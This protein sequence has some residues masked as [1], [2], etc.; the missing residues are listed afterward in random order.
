MHTLPLYKTEQIDKLAWP[1]VQRQINLHSPALSIVTDFTEQ[2]PQVIDSDTAAVALESLMKHSHVKMKI[3]L[4]KHQ[5]FAGIVTLADLT[6]QRILQKVASGI[7]RH[8]LTAQDF[9]QPKTALQSFDY[10]QLVNARVGDVVE[11]LKDNG[12]HHCLVTDRGAHEIRG[13]ISVSDIARTLRLPLDIYAQ[14]SFS[15]LSRILAA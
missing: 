4:D 5:Q 7:E 8:E 3:V 2:T 15:A 11:T 12:Q 1:T 10:A 6:E 13:V 9:M 14:P